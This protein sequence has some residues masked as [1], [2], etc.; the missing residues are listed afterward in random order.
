M[1][2]FALLQICFSHCDFQLFVQLKKFMVC[3]FNSILD[4][5]LFA[6]VMAICKQAVECVQ[7]YIHAF[8]L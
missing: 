4:N 3:N 2:Q 8:T 6:W 7:I 5:S 1:L